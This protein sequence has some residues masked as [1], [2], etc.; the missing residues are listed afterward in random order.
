MST[1]SQSA[2]TTQ[3]MGRRG[4]VSFCSSITSD[5][6]APNRGGWNGAL[7]GGGEW[8]RGRGGEEGREEEEGGGREEGVGEEGRRGGGEERRGRM[9]ESYEER[10]RGEEEVITSQW[11]MMEEHI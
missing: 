3:G 11:V 5:R 1:V 2:M 6:A 9:G 8:R 10:R 7:W 4:C